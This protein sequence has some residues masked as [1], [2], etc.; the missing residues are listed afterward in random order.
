MKSQL[1][2]TIIKLRQVQ[3]D[4]IKEENREDVSIYK[5]TWSSF[6]RMLWEDNELDPVGVFVWL[7]GSLSHGKAGSSSCELVMKE[8]NGLFEVQ[9]DPGG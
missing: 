3:G 4:V 8:R 9:K 5:Q 7:A 2:S 1:Y 6:I